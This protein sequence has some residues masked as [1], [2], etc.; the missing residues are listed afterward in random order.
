MEGW[1]M[2]GWLLA[3][4]VKF[5]LTPSAMVAR[6]IEP[7]WVVGVTT[8][9][10]A[11]GVSIFF[12]AGKALLSVL[13]FWWVRRGR[14]PRKFTPA[15]RRMVRWRQQYGL[16]GLLVLGVFLSV[17]LSSLLSAKYHGRD[18]RMP[19]AL[20]AAFFLWSLVLTGVS[21]AVREAI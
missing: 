9:G 16:T 11:I 1:E 7:L 12:Y 3:S 8:V 2:A 17:P 4:V 6:G 15:R 18:P 19:W 21:W 13:D 20:M 5:L 10:A 14:Q